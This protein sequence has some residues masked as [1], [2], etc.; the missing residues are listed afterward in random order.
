MFGVLAARALELKAWG[1]HA[2]LGLEG[3]LFAAYSVPSFFDVSV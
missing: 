2:V 3:L 1:L